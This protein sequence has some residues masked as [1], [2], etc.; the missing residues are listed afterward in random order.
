MHTHVSIGHDKGALPKLHT[1]HCLTSLPTL[2][3]VLAI[4]QL[5]KKNLLVNIV[6]RLA[7]ALG[8]DISESLGQAVTS[9]IALM[10]LISVGKQEKK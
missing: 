2:S 10:G 6:D 4:V 1:L 9:V 8:R 3:R 7:V 5:Y